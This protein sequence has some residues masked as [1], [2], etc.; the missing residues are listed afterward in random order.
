MFFFKKEKDI[1][2]AQIDK[3]VSKLDKLKQRREAMR[4]ELSQEIRKI[5]PEHVHD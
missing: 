3:T 5:I 2:A 4:E 1:L